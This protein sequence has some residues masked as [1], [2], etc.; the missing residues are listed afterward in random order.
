MKAKKIAFAILMIA[1]IGT[2]SGCVH[3]NNKSWDDLSVKEQQEVKQALDDAR[4]EIKDDFDDFSEATADLALE[5]VDKVQQD[6]T[7]ENHTSLY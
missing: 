2:M 1:L 6:I 5:I 7:K 3:L 4:E